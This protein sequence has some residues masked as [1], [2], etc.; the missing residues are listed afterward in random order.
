[1]NV[2]INP[3]RSLICAFALLFLLFSSA[4]FANPS[5]DKSQNTKKAKQ[6]YNAQSEK[7][8][9]TPEDQSRGTAADI[10]MTRQIRGEL[11]KEKNLSVS[12]QNIKIITLAG[13]AHLRGPV[14][15]EVEKDRVA[16][17]AKSVTGKSVEKDLEIKG[18]R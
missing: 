16:A 12:A 5:L 11:M 6:A 10:E 9:L 14:A 2:I 8:E 17:I 15:S 7:R 13:K 4:V 18:E 1:M 3:T